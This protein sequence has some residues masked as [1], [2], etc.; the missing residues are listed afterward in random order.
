MEKEHNSRNRYKSQAEFLTKQEYW[1]SCCCQHDVQWVEKTQSD[2]ILVYQSKSS[3]QPSP[4]LQDCI[5]Q[6]C[7]EGREKLYTWPK[8]IHDGKWSSLRLKERKVILQQPEK[9]DCCR[10][11]YTAAAGGPQLQYWLGSPTVPLMRERHAGRQSIKRGEG[12]TSPHHTANRKLA[13]QGRSIT[14]WPL[15]RIN[16]AVPHR[17]LWSLQCCRKCAYVYTYND[18]TCALITRAHCDWTCAEMHYTS[19]LGIVMHL[20]CERLFQLEKILYSLM[21]VLF[22]Q[23]VQRARL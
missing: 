8:Y 23:N 11:L 10:L 1:T 7:A 21:G 12:L 3:L 22:L 20:S 14:H 17:S 9:G 13:S 18:I 15:A 4:L 6:N 2:D 19:V 16:N 5:F